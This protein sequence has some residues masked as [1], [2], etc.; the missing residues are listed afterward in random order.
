MTV[1]ETESK[2]LI[3]LIKSDQ[4]EN[5][6][7]GLDI[8]L[9]NPKYKRV[10][11]KYNNLINRFTCYDDL[12]SGGLES[13]MYLMANDE[14]VLNYDELIGVILLYNS[15]DYLNIDKIEK[16]IL[17]NAK[18]IHD[19]NSLANFKNVSHLRIK[20]SIEEMPEVF[21][22]F[23]LYKLDIS[24]TYIEN[25][26]GFVYPL[27]YHFRMNKCMM[28]IPPHIK[29]SKYLKYLDVS[30]EFLMGNYGSMSY[31]KALTKLRKTIKGN[32]SLKINLI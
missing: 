10:Y 32:N 11:Q 24:D 28:D 12:E 17:K 20:G 3:R 15:M 21:K 30:E 18:K 29:E 13:L 7:I 19:Y 26:E 8:L 27:L 5:V 2:N 16:L 6:S 31:D 1:M 9:N 4:K 25:L 23:S 14:L 22:G